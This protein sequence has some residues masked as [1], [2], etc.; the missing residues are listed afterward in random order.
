M[1]IEKFQKREIGSSVDSL[2]NFVGISDGLMIMNYQSKMDLLFSLH[3]RSLPPIVHFAKTLTV[4]GGNTMAFFG[5]EV[6]LLLAVW[7]RPFPG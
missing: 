2:D 5:L 1:R 3:D 6:N 4:M 7:P